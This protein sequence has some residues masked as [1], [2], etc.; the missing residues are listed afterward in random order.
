MCHIS[1]SDVGSLGNILGN[2]CSQLSTVILDGLKLSG[3]AAVKELLGNV[4]F[5]ARRHFKACACMKLERIAPKLRF[6]QNS[7]YYH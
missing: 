5:P 4:W 1:A 7:V 3:T 6:T 2:P